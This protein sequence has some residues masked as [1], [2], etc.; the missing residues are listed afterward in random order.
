MTLLSLR[1]LCQPTLP[2]RGAGHPINFATLVADAIP[3]RARGKRIELWWQDEARV[4]QQGS[5]TYIWADRGSRPPALRDQRR[6]WAYIF[7]AVCPA[8]ETGIG[9]VLP[10][11]NAEA[12]NL[13]LAAV[14][15]AVAPDAFA[16]MLL[17][18][19]GWHQ[20]GG[21]LVVPENIGLLHLPPYSPEL[22][23][24]ENVWQYLRQNF[25]SNRVFEHYDAIVDA[26]CAAWNALM[27]LPARLHSITE[28]EWAKMVIA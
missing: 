6:D 24:V 19:A 17:D 13:H 14:S 5:L 1:S 18:G 20:T 25:L 23:P 28:R 9:L 11:A 3:E 8:R 21:R 22:N 27:A 10:E 4:G 7:G 15:Q 12:M 2:G 16:V 26:C